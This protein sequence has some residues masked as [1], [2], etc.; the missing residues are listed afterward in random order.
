MIKGAFIPEILGCHGSI[1]LIRLSSPNGIV[2]I[3]E[4]ESF[5][6]ILVK[7]CCQD[8]LFFDE[9]SSQSSV[10]NAVG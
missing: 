10:I 8:C 7:S 2:G 1:G 6:T 3:V 9:S 5:D 4:V